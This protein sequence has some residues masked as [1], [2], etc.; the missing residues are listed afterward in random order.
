MEATEEE[1]RVGRILGL[2]AQVTLLCRD[3]QLT[4]QQKWDK[5]LALMPVD[6]AESESA[7]RLELSADLTSS[8][9]SII[10]DGKLTRAEKLSAIGKLLDA[11]AKADKAA[12]ALESVSL[13]SSLEDVADLLHTNGP[14]LPRPS[15]GTGAVTLN[16]PLDDVCQRLIAE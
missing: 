10:N 9:A 2:T 7:A 6:S 15:A 13:E 5:L 8:V 11:H 1:M 3:D 12:S 4:G 14:L 16:T